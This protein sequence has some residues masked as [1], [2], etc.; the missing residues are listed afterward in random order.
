MS[1]LLTFLTLKVLFFPVPDRQ[2]MA[3]DRSPEWQSGGVQGR[4]GR[5]PSG[6]TLQAGLCRWET[7]AASTSLALDA[8]STLALATRELTAVESSLSLMLE[9]EGCG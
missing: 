2:T 4:E 5:L 9:V 6:A 1:R 7:A 8:G 3:S